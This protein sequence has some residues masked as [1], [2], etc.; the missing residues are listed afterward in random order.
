MSLKK[1][2]HDQ[3]PRKNFEGPERGRVVRPAANTFQWLALP[4]LNFESLD[5]GKKGLASF[6]AVSM[7]R[8]FIPFYFSICMRRLKMADILLTGPFEHHLKLS[9]TNRSIVTAMAT[10]LWLNT[11]YSYL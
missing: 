1:I 6:V 2:F 9:V 8:T 5:F 7:I 11:S 4:T 10:L 3:Y